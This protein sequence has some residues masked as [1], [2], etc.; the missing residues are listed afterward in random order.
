M[1]CRGCPEAHM[2]SGAVEQMLQRPRGCSLCKS[3]SV[4][5]RHTVL[6][7]GVSTR[8]GWPGG[9]LE[10][11]TSWNLRAAAGELSCAPEAA[12]QPPRGVTWGALWGHLS[13]QQPP[14]SFPETP[15]SALKS[16]K[17]LCRPETAAV[18]RDALTKATDTSMGEEDSSGYRGLDHRRTLSWPPDPVC[19]RPAHTWLSI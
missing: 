19:H 3:S 6:P 12:C 2:G 17:E 5:P 14:G 13:C 1:A 7:C 15:V 16:Q 11:L 10:P 18:L 4:E 8:D 9:G